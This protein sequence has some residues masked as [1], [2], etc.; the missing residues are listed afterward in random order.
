MKKEGEF[1][2]KNKQERKAPPFFLAYWFHGK[3]VFENIWFNSQ[4]MGK[5]DDISYL[6]S[7][8][9]LSYHYMFSLVTYFILISHCWKKE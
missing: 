5:E 9:I 6:L 3:Y 8:T 4:C 7:Q 1:A 2:L